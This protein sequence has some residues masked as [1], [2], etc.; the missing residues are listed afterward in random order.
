[1][2]N[3]AL[4]VSFLD[5]EFSMDVMEGAVAAAKELEVNLFIIPT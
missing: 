5:N 2:K 1:M 4:F 3:I